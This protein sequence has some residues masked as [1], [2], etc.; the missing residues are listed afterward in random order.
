MAD[1]RRFDAFADFL[2]QRFD[3]PRIWDVAGG[4]GRLNAALTARGRETT[5]FDLRWKR[6][7]HL[8]YEERLLTLDEPCAC[9]LVVG[10][11]PDGATRVVVEYAAR[12][13]LPFAVVPCCADNSMSYKPWLRHIEDLAQ[14]LGLATERAELP[15]DGRRTVI[16]G[17]PMDVDGI[18]GR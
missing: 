12:H 18:G 2:C 5:T 17:R 14:A 15:I 11:H 1:L 16:V 9:D 8:R 3:A 6:L 7:P 10:L 13:R 4:Q